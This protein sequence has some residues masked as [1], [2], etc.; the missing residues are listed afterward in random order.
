M[1]YRISELSIKNFKCI[2]SHVFDFDEKNLIVFDGPNGYGK[3]TVFEAI[4]IVLTEKPR[5][6]EYIKSDA[7]FSFE[8][9]PIHKTDSESIN[10]SLKLNNGEETISVQRVF[11]AATDL[12]P[13]DRNIKNVFNH[14]KLYINNEESDLDSLSEVLK[15]SNIKDFFNVLN[16]VEQDE[17]TFFIKKDPKD[18]YN[19]L[20]SLLGVEKQKN[21]LDRI[22][23]FQNK[24]K[25]IISKYNTQRG[26]I[27]DS[28]RDFL[29]ENNEEIEY[30]RLIESKEF[31][32]DIK[33]PEIPNL[34]IR[35]SFF[36]ELDKVAYLKTNKES[37]DGI[38]RFKLLNKFNNDEFLSN[39]IKNYWNLNNLEV[40]EKENNQ[41]EYKVRLINE[42]GLLIKN[43]EDS[44]YEELVK[45]LSINT[46]KKL[47]QFKNDLEFFQ[48]SL[49]I[50]IESKKNLSSQ[51]KILENLKQKRQDLIDL[52]K[53]HIVQINL[54]EG[55]CP[56]CGFN[57]EEAEVLYAKIEET[58]SKIFKL[59][60][61]ANANLE[62]T[63]DDLKNTYFKLIKEYCLNEIELNNKAIINLISLSEFSRLK[64]VELVLRKEI[65][66][67]L[68]SLDSKYKDKI[69]LE[70]NKRKI[71]NV[72]EIKLIIISIIKESLPN[73]DENLNVS[74]LSSD[75]EHYFNNE[76][77]VL[78]AISDKNLKQKKEYIDFVYFNTI[79]LKINELNILLEKY[80]TLLD[81]IKHIKNTVDAE[82]INYTNGI[83]ENISIPF[84]IYT[85]KILQEHTLGTG[86]IFNF[87]PK[88]HQVVLKPVNRD[89]EVSYTLSSGQLSATVISLMLVL[90]K[91]YDN[92]VLGT[93]L[94]DD[95]LQTLDEINTHSLIEVLKYNFS[96]HQIILSTHEDRYS[97]FI[98]Y[99]YDRFNL[100]HRNIRMKEIL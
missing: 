32:W 45:D 63:K 14:S 89:Q 79:N 18:R 56:T 3:T 25:G 16:Y 8:N 29:S 67:F 98:R 88:G 90:N 55:E 71:E 76:L 93:I 70:I 81:D 91:V 62:K 65:D 49:T 42:F 69:I 57:W 31:N 61:E 94:I 22:T 44:N 4:E 7:R 72:D 58:E 17:N 78:D 37:L 13:Q 40:L 59:Y 41:R 83:I 60:N 85:G 34:D 50:I 86:L 52:N 73:L 43:I 30:Q 96:D 74:Q 87:D 46:I 47:S 33:K 51:Y 21:Q 9:S 99:K 23:S 48:V 35:N 2:D 38:L 10:I 75:F 100:S 27:E 64:E 77:A 92:S 1:I 5:Y 66:M 36:N 53:E 39:L 11:P 19:D 6:A 54:E 95:P 26:A 84:Y 68:K 82:L 12:N 97:K 24:L 80:H 15:Y 20:V 28:N